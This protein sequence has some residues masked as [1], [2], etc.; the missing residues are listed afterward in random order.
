MD[1]KDYYA[2]VKNLECKPGTSYAQWR[3]S[4]SLPCY[5]MI[6]SQTKQSIV[7]PNE[8]HPLFLLLFLGW[9]IVKLL[10]F[11]LLGCGFGA[12]GHFVFKCWSFFLAVHLHMW[13]NCCMSSQLETYSVVEWYVYSSIGQ[14]SSLKS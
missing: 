13:L 1:G 7:P 8:L 3:T 14:F 4:T 5:D 6:S 9:N 11:I 12:W 2:L 10:N